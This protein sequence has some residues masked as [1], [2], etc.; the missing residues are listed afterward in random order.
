MSTPLLVKSPLRRVPSR[1]PGCPS[2]EVPQVS[3]DGPDDAP[4]TRRRGRVCNLRS[5]AV[6]TRS[7]RQSH[8]R[9]AWCHSAEASWRFYGQHSTPTQAWA[10]APGHQH[11]VTGS[12]QHRVAGS[13]QHRVA[14][15]HQHRVA[16]SHQHR[17]AGSL[18]HRVVGSHPHRAAGSRQLRVAGSHQH[19][20][21]GSH[22]HRVAGSHQRRVAGSHQHRVAGS[23]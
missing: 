5:V 2:P 23:H 9:Q 11:R 12:H 1:V 18:Q 6:R 7:R 13:H 4:C 16:G 21:A 14:G 3:R 10:P 17:A 22:L 15:S 8:S 19:M 20:V